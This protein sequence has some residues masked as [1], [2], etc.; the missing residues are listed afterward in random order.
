M[1]MLNVGD[2]QVKVLEVKP[3]MS[4]QAMNVATEYL[5]I[6]DPMGQECSVVGLD[7][8]PTYS[9]DIRLCLNRNRTNQ[10][11]PLPPS[12]LAYQ[13]MDDEISNGGESLQTMLRWLM[14]LLAN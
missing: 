1:V 11:W 2:V 13:D 4:L 9:V 8:G 5:A 3:T 10:S 12:A 7:T 14:E 6:L